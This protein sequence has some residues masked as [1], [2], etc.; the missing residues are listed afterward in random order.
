[1]FDEST[2][3]AKINKQIGRRIEETGY[4]VH[5]RFTILHLPNMMIMMLFMIFM[6][7]GTQGTSITPF[8]SCGTAEEEVLLNSNDLYITDVVSGVVDKNGRTKNCFK[9]CYVK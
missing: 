1:M 7:Q 3:Q 5:L 4:S 8:S 2:N 6:L 9:I